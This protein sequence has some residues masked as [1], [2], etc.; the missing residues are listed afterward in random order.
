MTRTASGTSHSVHYLLLRH[1]IIFDL[2]IQEKKTHI[3]FFL[4]YGITDGDRGLYRE[5]VDNLLD[6]DP[7][8][9]IRLELDEEEDSAVYTWPVAL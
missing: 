1:T 2:N 7:L 4:L 9:P 3:Y 6:V 5:D 8:E